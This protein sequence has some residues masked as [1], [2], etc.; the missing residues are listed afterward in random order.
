MPK[1]TIP[2][3]Y[4]VALII[5]I[6]VIAVLVYM[7]LTHTG[8]FSGTATAAWCQGKKV[9]YC[10]KWAQ[11]SA[12]YAEDKRPTEDWDSFAPGCKDIGVGSPSSADCK[13]T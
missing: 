3:P 12:D 9:E 2:V 5:A 8:I 7:F 13:L 4:I 6:V 10:F 11:R 1:G